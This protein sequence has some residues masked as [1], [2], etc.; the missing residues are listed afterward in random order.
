MPFVP[1]PS[2]AHAAALSFALWIGYLLVMAAYKRRV[3]GT[4][5][6]G[7]LYGAYALAAV[8]GLLDVFYNLTIGN[9]VFWSAPRGMTLSP[10]TWTF[11]AR[12]QYWL[13]KKDG[14][15][16][17]RLAYAICHYLLDPFAPNGRHCE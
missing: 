2:F 6:G 16:R 14:S 4:L 17:F 12:C 10:R 3:A 7:L 15:L 1:I 11:T 13:R 5:T 9:V 8:V